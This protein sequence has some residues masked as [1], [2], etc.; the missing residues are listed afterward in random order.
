MH[1]ARPGHQRALSIEWLAK[2]ID[3][4]SLPTLIGAETIIRDHKGR[5]PDLCINPSIEWLDCQALGIDTDDLADLYLAISLETDL[6]PQ[7]NEL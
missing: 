2:S 5:R 3:D 7:L 4:P 1:G 6:I